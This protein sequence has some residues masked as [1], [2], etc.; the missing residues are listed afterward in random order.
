MEGV[1]AA[2]RQGRF[3]EGRLTLSERRSLVES[4]SDGEVADTAINPATRR[5]MEP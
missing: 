2:D 1:D 4:R 3:G 5:W